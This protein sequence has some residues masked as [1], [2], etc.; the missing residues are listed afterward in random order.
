M[1]ISPRTRKAADPS[2]HG[3]GHAGIVAI[4]GSE[5]LSGARPPGSRLPSVDQMFQTFGVSRVVLREVTRTLAAKG[6][7]T[8]KTKIGTLVLDS[9][10]WNWLDPQVLEWRG[11]LGLDQAFL[12]HITE[13]RLAVEPAAARLAARHRSRQD[14]AQMRATLNAMR[15]AEGNHHKFSQADLAFHAAVSAASGNPLFRSFISATEV[16]LFG[17]LRMISVGV[18]A[19]EKTHARS[20]ARHAKIA[21]AIEA[22][23]EDAA[24]RAMIR[25]VEE[26]FRHARGSATGKKA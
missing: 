13:V 20:A 24:T 17:F 8:S 10:H 4:L 14:L 15:E 19:D 26:G 16:A 11:K 7:V 18:I 2:N 23:N 21:D 22:R 5:I 12:D 6:M 1:A 25:V 3:Q 9:A